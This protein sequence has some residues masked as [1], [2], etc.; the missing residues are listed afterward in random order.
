MPPLLACFP[1]CL[2]FVALGI[3]WVVV[4][5]FGLAHPT[6]DGQ[7]ARPAENRPAGPRVLSLVGV[8]LLMCLVLAALMLALAWYW[9]E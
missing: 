2:T 9:P 6:S 3:I 1:V 5:A 7:T 8:F 4:V